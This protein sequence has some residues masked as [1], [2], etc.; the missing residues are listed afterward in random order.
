MNSEIKTYLAIGDSYTIGEMVAP[1]ENFPNQ[2]AAIMRKAGIAVAVPRVIAKTGWTTDELEWGI[3]EADGQEPLTPPYDFVSLLIG[4]N[5]QYRGRP[6][7]DY[8]PAFEALLKKAISFAGGKPQHVV[9][10][11]I[12]DWGVTPFAEGR[13]RDEIAAA[14]DSYNS[15]NERI[16][17]AC[18]V[19][20]INITPATRKAAGDSSLLARDGLHPSGKA[21]REWAIQVAAFFLRK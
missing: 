12:P 1:A 5:D 18:Q 14:I 15:V 8:E 4:V 13:N 20:Y 10:L 11:S 6:V 19:H 17:S 16:A 9:V 7:S 2:A 21:Y 3:K